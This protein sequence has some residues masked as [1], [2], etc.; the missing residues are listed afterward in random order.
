MSA[1]TWQLTGVD[2]YTS[3]FWLAQWLA[4]WGFGAGLIIGPALVI[5][6][7]GLSLDEAMMLA[8]V[9]NISRALPAFIAAT[10][11]STL[12]TQTTDAHFDTLRQNVQFN[13]PLVE[14]SYTSAQ[15][16][17][18]ARG[19]AEGTSVQQSHALIGRW[20]QANSKAFALQDVFRCLT[21]ATAIG[22]IAVLALPG[23]KLQSVAL[24][25]PDT[26]RAPPALKSHA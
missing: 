2:L 7:E 25:P 21:M 22:L 12:W 4:V 3:K 16:H 1:V 11:L 20:A 15:R 17:F 9:F 14:E 5:I 23:A 18:I 26:R 13:R 10:I 8:G 19:S 24:S 6:F